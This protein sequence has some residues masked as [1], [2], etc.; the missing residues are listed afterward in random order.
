[1]PGTVTVPD[2]L[3]GHAADIWRSAFLS[4]YDGT[5]KDR[6]DQRDS[7]GAA[8]AWSAVKNKYKKNAQGEWV[9]RADDPAAGP[10]SV[11]A[12]DEY[13]SAPVTEVEVKSN[14]LDAFTKALR[15]ECAQADDP[16]TCA[17]AAADALHPSD[18]GDGDEE[19]DMHMDSEVDRTFTPVHRNDMGDLSLPLVIRKDYSPEKRAEFS[20]SGI[21]LPDGSYPIADKAD[22]RDA[23]QS[24]GRAPASKQAQVRAHIT[25][26]AKALGA[27]E[28]VSSEWGGE[29]E[30]PKAEVKSTVALTSRA[31]LRAK[32]AADD[33]KLLASPE[34]ELIARRPDHIGSNEWAARPAILRTVR[35]LVIERSVER[36]YE[37]A[38]ERTVAEGWQPISNPTRA[39]EYVF[40]RW[41]DTPDGQ[42]L[43]RSILVRRAETVGDWRLRE[44]TRGASLSLA[45]QVPADERRYGD[46]RP[47]ELL[48]PRGGPGSGHFSHEGIPG[49]RGGSLPGEGGGTTSQGEKAKGSGA[50]SFHP[51]KGGPGIRDDSKVGGGG[52][53]GSA[54]VRDYKPADWNKAVDTLAKLPLA[55]LRRR[56]DLNKEQLGTWGEHPDRYDSAAGRELDMIQDML[57]QAVDKREFGGEPE[58]PGRFNAEMQQ[59][60]APRVGDLNTGPG[61]IPGTQ[62][63]P[64]DFGVKGIDY[65]RERP[66]TPE[67]HQAKIAEDTLKMP[68]AMAAV[69]GGPTKAEA[70]E[71]LGLAP[72]ANEADSSHHLDEYG[73]SIANDVGTALAD[74]T[75]LKGGRAEVL[76]DGNLSWVK[77]YRD[78][79]DKQGT[80]ISPKMPASAVAAYV[81]GNV[82]E[83]NRIANTG[84]KEPLGQWSSRGGKWGAELYRQQMPEGV[85]YGYTETKGGSST[86]F[87]G[88]QA[89]TEADAIAE[90]QKLV[91]EGRF[92]ADANR[93]PMKFVPV[94]APTQRFVITKT[95]ARALLQRLTGKVPQA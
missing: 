10:M 9:E 38:V 60:R 92:Q 44:L 21:A 4:A 1:M 40:Q 32:A 2:V 85:R 72:S 94:R 95:D 42:L 51:H 46:T 28:S 30:K 55:E 36:S 5:C 80:E 90:M 50:P 54:R 37:D 86:G 59:T 73:I 88:L 19:V 91:D 31:V 87:G 8:I 3:K 76:S 35:A 7:C 6:G 47:F 57:M 17:V 48:T 75:A 65:S 93:S 79:N 13:P 71:T 83:E 22:L 34:S 62:L 41:L 78:E 74:Y 63:I 68:D 14:W 39:G 67:E 43:Q 66:S 11:M 29:A 89:T 56:Q 84:E 64:E 53:G 23:I 25:K 70:R 33:E 12:A 20:K 61:A 49:H 82:W 81:S 18:E 26:R 77:W 58:M 24:F 69:M 15:G 45:V 52:T 27:Q 16:I